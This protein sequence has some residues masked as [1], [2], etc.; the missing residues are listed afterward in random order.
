MSDG[1]HAAVSDALG[2]RVEALA[3]AYGFVGTGTSETHTAFGHT[4]TVTTTASS[5]DNAINKDEGT[6]TVIIDGKTIYS[7]KAGNVTST[8][9]QRILDALEVVSVRDRA[10]AQISR[11]ETQ[12]VTRVLSN[13][14]AQV[15]SPQF[16]LAPRSRADMKGDGNDVHI[17]SSRSMTG[18]SSGDAGKSFGVWANA[19]GSI[20]NDYNSNT[21]S[22]G[23]SETGLAG[24]DYRLGDVVVGLVGSGENTNLDTTFNKGT[25]SRTGGSVGPYAAYSLFNNKVVLDAFANFGWGSNTYKQPIGTAS[26]S[27]RYGSER[28]IYG[29]HAT[30]AN[31]IDDWD[32][33]L[34]VGYTYSRDRAESYRQSDDVPFAPQFTRVGEWSLRGKA[35]WSLGNFHPYGGLAYLRDTLMP[36]TYVSSSATESAAN[37]KDEVEAMLGLDYYIKDALTASFEVSHG[38]FRQDENNTSLMVNCRYQF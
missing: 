23:F 19:T 27:G 16:R 9:A 32:Y 5:I 15:F 20:L 6:F 2:G 28:R 29:A 21:A 34:K 33:S 24:I 1:A 3:H 8:D 14:L 30:Y 17:L 11:S 18:I 10:T 31:T 36:M 38:F 37:D 22:D 7:G 12:A 13:R 4:W 35:G 26:V 25:F